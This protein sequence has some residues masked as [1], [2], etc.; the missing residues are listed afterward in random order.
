VYESREVTDC[1][2][3]KVPQPVYVCVR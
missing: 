3:V 2:W 1:Q